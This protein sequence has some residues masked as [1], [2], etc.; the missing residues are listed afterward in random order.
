[1]HRTS[2]AALELTGLTANLLFVDS[3]TVLVIAIFIVIISIIVIVRVLMTV[4][5][6]AMG[7]RVWAS[8]IIV[9]IRVRVF[10]IIVGVL[11]F[12]IRV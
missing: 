5:G 1:M 8:V 10:F 12:F 4:I 7:C 6:M 11:Y 9:G 3:F 2:P